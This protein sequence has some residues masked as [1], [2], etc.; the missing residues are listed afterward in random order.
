MKE[1]NVHQA[2]ESFQSEME[3][4]TGLKSSRFRCSNDGQVYTVNGPLSFCWMGRACCRARALGEAMNTYEM[5]ER[6]DENREPE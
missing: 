3:R 4:E 1:S 6:D 2:C 5:M